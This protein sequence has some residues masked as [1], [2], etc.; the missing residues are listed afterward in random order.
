MEN[1]KSGAFGLGSTLTTAMAGFYAYIEKEKGF[2]GHTLDAY[3][4]DLDQFLSFLESKELAPS[5][6]DTMKKQVLRS[7]AFS[8]SGKGLKSR[9]IARKIA[10]LKSGK[11]PLGAEA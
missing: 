8:L 2:S 11:A 4:S 10:A 9:S 3:R 1:T 5:L 6:E 7:F